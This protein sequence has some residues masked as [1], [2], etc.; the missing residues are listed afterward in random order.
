MYVCTDIDMH[1]EIPTH[2]SPPEKQKLSATAR[3]R[4][5]LSRECAARQIREDDAIKAERHHVL[6]QR[7]NLEVDSGDHHW[8]GNGSEAHS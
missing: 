5:S 4:V 3:K 7:K 8:C 1:I 6:R 2:E